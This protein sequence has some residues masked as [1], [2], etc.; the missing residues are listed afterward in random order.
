[1]IEPFCPGRLCSVK[2]NEAVS[3][4]D[5]DE[6]AQELVA[7][8]ELPASSG[9]ILARLLEEGLTLDLE[10]LSGS[11]SESRHESVVL[12]SSEDSAATALAWLPSIGPNQEPLLCVG[13]NHGGISLFTH[14]GAVCSSFVLSPRRVLRIRTCQRH[15]A[16]PCS[17]EDQS[18]QQLPSAR[19]DQ[20]QLLHEHGVLV[21]AEMESIR[22]VAFAKSAASH[23]KSLSED[24]DAAKDLRFHV[25]ELRGRAGITDACIVSAARSLEDPFA[26]LNGTADSV[27]AVALG[28][29]PFLSLHSRRTGVAASNGSGRSLLGSAASALGSYAR[30]WVPFRGKSSGG[31]TSA[32]L[33]PA[34][35]LEPAGLCDARDIQVLSSAAASELPVAAKFIDTRQGEL[36]LPAPQGSCD[37]AALAAT[38][39][40][41]G[42]VALFCVETLRCLHLWKG[43][44]DAQIAW[45]LPSPG[46]SPASSA[47]DEAFET[48]GASRP[49]LVIHAPR[50]G[51]LELWKLGSDSGPKRIA[52]SAVGSGCTLL[53]APGSRAHLLRP[54]GQLDRIVWPP[55]GPTSPSASCG[56]VASPGGSKETDSDAFDSAGSEGEEPQVSPATGTIDPEHSSK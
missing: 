14:R 11:Q 22:E 15:P 21:L 55:L 25:Y 12:A 28:S 49:G 23:G 2:A 43:Y 50:R 48:S 33:P 7:S 27:A 8:I 56:G 18:R 10:F 40:A 5:G 38:C 44:R 36:L 13:F 42:R 19:P 16:A 29:Q 45:I 26:S 35:P 51:L 3:I 6:E 52:A 32:E 47:K 34:G 30:S 46:G 24:A 20:L 37:D 39:D 41:Y 54:C 9:A 53:A 17:A 4:A 1:M 31:N